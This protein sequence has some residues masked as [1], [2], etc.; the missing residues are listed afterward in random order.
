[1]K[2]TSK[3]KRIFAGLLALL[4]IVALLPA[5]SAQVAKAAMP[6]IDTSKT[7]SLTIHKYEYN[8]TNGSTGTGE[9]TDTVPADATPLK[10][11]TFKVSYVA[12]LTDYYGTDGA[13]LPT[14]DA[15][16]T[17][18]QCATASDK[19][20]G[21]FTPAVGEYMTVTTNASGEATLSTLPLGIYLVQETAAPAQIT[22]KTAD[23][24]VSIPMTNASEDDWLYNVHV[25]PKNSSTYASVTLLKNGVVGNSTSTN[26]VKGATFKLEVRSGDAAPYTWTQVKENNKGEKIGTDVNNDGNISGANE[27]GILTT[28]DNGK[29]TVSDLAPGHYRF[30]EIAVP[31]KTGYIAD[32][33]A[34]YEF[35]VADKDAADG[36]S[37]KAGDILVDGKKV[38]TSQ[39]PITVTNYKPDIEKEVKDRTGTWDNDADYS[40]GDKIPYR[41]RIDV[42]KNVSSLRSFEIKDT[43]TNQTYVA[44]SLKIYSDAALA[45]QI[46]NKT[47]PTVA[48]D[49]KSWSIEFNTFTASSGSTTTTGTTSLLETYKGKSIYIYFEAELTSDA[50]NGSA[51]NKNTAE[52]NYSN[53]IVPAEDPDNPGNDVP[54]PKKD[55]IHDEAIVYTFQLEVQKVTE[56]KTTPLEGVEFDLYRLLNTGEDTTGSVTADDIKGL[57]AGNFIKVNSTSLKTDANGKIS[58]NGLENGTYYLVET[59]TA[60][61]Y[62]LLKAPVKV[63]INA[64]YS[65]KT[66]TTT[67]TDANGVTTTETTVTTDTYTNN[68]TSNDGI[69]ISKIVN[70][71]GFTLPTTG[72]MGTAIF[73]FVG[74]SMMAAAVILF[75]LSR[76]KDNAKQQ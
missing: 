8:G 70:N 53:E 24:L 35:E 61:T 48:G 22:G 33:L 60:D 57:P 21:S 56:D 36:T 34:T 66:E 29:I 39:N 69:V 17:T 58:V 49:K 18:L 44:D 74:V 6:T 45:T 16:K 31:D 40:I 47:S 14:V 9:S 55:I 3:I 71:K 75:F 59:K 42:P 62:N 26:I 11:V 13:A 43:L 54:D 5:P 64:S 50:V 37:Y 68:G 15:A 10:D 46:L 20:N 38:D 72:G 63:E 4:M 30:V 52:L 2:K 67:T 76:K 27:E 19:T 32:K 65:V 1:M 25:F 12:A 51:G 41:I 73:V 28:N 23:F 7:G